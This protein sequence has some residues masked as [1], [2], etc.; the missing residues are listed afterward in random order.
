VLVSAEGD[1]LLCDF[2]LSR[3]VEEIVSK[4]GSSVGRGGGHARFM[5]PELLR[6]PKDAPLG[7]RPT[8]ESDVF[9]FA[10]LM[11]QVFTLVFC[12]TYACVAHPPIDLY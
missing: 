11:L 5:A 1:A 6:P 8:P 9:A 2:G 10:S 3:Y 12:R 7:S 4:S